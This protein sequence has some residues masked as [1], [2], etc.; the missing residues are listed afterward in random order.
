[1]TAAHRIFLL[2]HGLLA[3]A[4][5]GV[6]AALAGASLDAV[7]AA[8]Y[9]DGA[10]AGVSLVV[11]AAACILLLLAG[12]GLWATTG[13]RRYALVSD[14]LVLA[15][16]WWLLLVVLLVIWTP[17]AFVVVLGLTLLCPLVAIV[18]PGPTRALR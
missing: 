10:R 5:L 7:G 8:G 6:I 15:L 11:V 1:M 2:V 3:L 9:V 17:V 16:T 12:V 18:V 4:L 14:A 13:R